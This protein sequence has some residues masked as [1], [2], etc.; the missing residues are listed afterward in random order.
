MSSQSSA[1]KAA[2][3][4]TSQQQLKRQR[5]WVYLAHFLSLARLHPLKTI[6]GEDDG[7]EPDFTCV[8]AKQGGGECYIG[9]ELT[10]LPRLRDRLG[11]D[12][13]M[14]KRWYWQSLLQLQS[15]FQPTPLVASSLSA[16]FKSYSSVCPD[17]AHTLATP[18]K[19]M[20]S[21]NRQTWGNRLQQ[22]V[23]TTMRF[24]PSAFFDDMADSR[25]VPIDSVID[26]R[27]IDAVM[28]KKASK[29]E[30]YQARRPLDAVWLLIHTNEQQED[31]LLVA[32]SS[33][34]LWHNSDFARV[35]VT[36][37]PNAELHE[38]KK[39]PDTVNQ[40]PKPLLNMSTRAIA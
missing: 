16:S 22:A 29:T 4:P 5:E 7:Q 2:K 12:N 24:L 26:Q 33:T 19:P 8:F 40:S 9:I 20:A 1:N 14:L 35:F 10:T 32:D 11:N 15:R 6:S 39:H 17:T 3:S 23:A 31:G 18:V 13:L 30:A 25:G 28:E 27:D 34:P 36:L 38:V 21:P 37:Y